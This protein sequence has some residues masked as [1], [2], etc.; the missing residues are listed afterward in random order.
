M[1]YCPKC[2]SEYREGYGICSDC[3]SPL[4]DRL[5]QSIPEAHPGGELVPVLDLPDSIMGQALGS[6][7]EDNGITCTVRSEQIPMYDGVAMMLQPRWG[8]LM[9]LEG[10]RVRAEEIIQGY[11]S[12]PEEPEPEG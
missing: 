8:R 9:V 10:D 11:L 6:L 1:K 12:V 5:A 2:R 4:V 3:G 7:L